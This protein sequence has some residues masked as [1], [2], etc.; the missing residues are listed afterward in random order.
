LESGRLSAHAETISN[1]PLQ[2]GL[3]M[4]ICAISDRSYH[5]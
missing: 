3:I 1:G 5:V 4:S 2:I